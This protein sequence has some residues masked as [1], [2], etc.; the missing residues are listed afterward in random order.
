MDFIGELP[1]AHGYNAIMVVV[2]RLSKRAHFIPTHTTLDASGT[3]RI[4][5]KEVWR[6]HGLPSDVVSDRGVQ[7][8][9]DFTR[10]LYRLLD[11]KVSASTA[12]HPQSDG[13]TERVNQELETFLRAFINDRQDNWDELLIW[14][15]FA[16]NNHTHIS[17]GET[18]FMLDSGQH[19]RMG[20][21]PAY[22][23][24][25]ESVNEF[26]TRMET[27]VIEVRAAISKAK[28]NYARYYNQR[29]RPAPAL[30]PGDKVWLDSSDICTHHPS[31]KLEHCWWGLYEVIKEVGKG[32]FKLKLPL[33]MH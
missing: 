31:K 24:M 17:T 12:Y 5:A 11:I 14:A 27:A 32:A 13:Q 23:S 33:S 4:F 26:K 16:Y 30:T 15:E 19:P 2:D 3:A 8:V 20:F 29:C 18:P 21:E 25:L 10:E 22:P 9:A 28:D 1:D 7:F 6:H